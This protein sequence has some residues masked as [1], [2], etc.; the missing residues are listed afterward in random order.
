LNP[1]ELPKLGVELYVVYCIS[2]RDE[3]APSPNGEEHV[4]DFIIL[5]SLLRHGPVPVV[6]TFSPNF[7][8]THTSVNY[9]LDSPMAGYGTLRDIT[10][11]HWEIHKLQ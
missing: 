9:I 6:S 3:E 2:L 7:K 10:K 5:A 4:Q 1:I 11:A 8:T